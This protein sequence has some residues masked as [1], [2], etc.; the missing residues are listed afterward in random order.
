[1]E[2]AKSHNNQPDTTAL[3]LKFSSNRAWNNRFSI[4]DPFAVNAGQGHCLSMIDRHWV[5]AIIE[6]HS[7]EEKSVDNS[8]LFK[9]HV[10]LLRNKGCGR[11]GFTVIR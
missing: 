10:W 9:V 5:Q 6:I 3:L 2:H 8:T 7:E 1:M 4:V 11:M